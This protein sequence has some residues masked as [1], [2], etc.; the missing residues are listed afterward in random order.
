ML[1]IVQG[2]LGTTANCFMKLL[3]SHNNENYSKVMLRNNQRNH[4][5]FMWNL[6]HWVK[7][8]DAK[9]KPSKGVHRNT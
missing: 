8:F 2:I 3:T 5:H 7:K 1:V 4:F 9:N 6:G